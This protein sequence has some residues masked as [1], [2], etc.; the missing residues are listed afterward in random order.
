MSEDLAAALAAVGEAAGER[1]AGDEDCSSIDHE[2][3]DASA[4]TNTDADGRSLKIYL[5]QFRSKYLVQ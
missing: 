4:V 5:F 2:Q 1:C 3:D